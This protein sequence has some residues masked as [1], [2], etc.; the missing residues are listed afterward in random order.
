MTSERSAGIEDRSVPGHWEGDL[1]MGKR[2][3]SIGT[4]VE[5]NSRYWGC[6]RYQATGQ[7]VSGSI[8]PTP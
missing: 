1:I 2:K 6:S 5:R 4:L 7:R 8:S 3:T